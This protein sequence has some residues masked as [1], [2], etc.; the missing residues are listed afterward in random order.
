MAPT[1]TDVDSALKGVDLSMLDLSNQSLKGIDLRNARLTGTRLV[2][3]VLDSANLAGADLSG[4]D[5]TNASLRSAN[6]ASAQVAGAVLN[7]AN[8]FRA[9]LENVTLGA[10]TTNGETILADSTPG[11]YRREEDT[12]SSLD[13]AN[14]SRSRADGYVWIGNYSR[15]RGEWEKVRIADSAD[16][17][18]T[19]DP[20]TLE[21]KASYRLRGDLT[22]RKSLPTNDK[23]YFYSIIAL[24]WIPRGSTVKLLGPPVAYARPNGRTQFW[25]HVQVDSTGVQD[26]GR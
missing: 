3:A 21:L 16:R 18:I 10:A 5:L 26:M 15:E 1:P 7:G 17:P 20:A 12:G 25:A 2:N 24:G 14:V 22:L 4:A 11:P 13:T 23:A 19:R 8:L 6:L 9:R